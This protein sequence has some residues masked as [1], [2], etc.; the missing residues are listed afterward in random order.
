LAPEISDIVFQ[1]WR[2]AEQKVP[3]NQRKG[4]NSLVMLVAM[5]T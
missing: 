2:E 5:K 3:K 4:F 1:E